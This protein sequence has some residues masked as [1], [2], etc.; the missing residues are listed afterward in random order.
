[1]MVMVNIGGI[2]SM[3]G[4][5][6]LLM[7]ENFKVKMLEV[8]YSKLQKNMRDSYVENVKENREGFSFIEI[9]QYF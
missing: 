1:M 4:L 8:I 7:K 9:C 5:L 2:Y 3:G 6:K